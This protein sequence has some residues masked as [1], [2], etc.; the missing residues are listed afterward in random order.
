MNSFFYQTLYQVKQAYLSLQQ[1]PGF[2]FSVVTTLGITLGALLCVL[3]LAYVMLIKPLPYPDQDRLYR[4]E[5]QLISNENKV[6]GRAFTYPNLMHLYKNQ[7]T[8]SESVLSYFD[9]AVLTSSTDEPMV[10]ISF[11]T[12]QWFDIFATKMALGRPFES[13]EQVNTYNPVAIL[14]YQTWQAEFAGKDNILDEKIKFSGK[15][16]RVIGVT[17]QQNIE[18]PLAGPGYKTQIY[19][20]WD[21]NPTSDKQRLAWGND[22][23]GLSFIGKIK[24]ELAATFSATQMNQTLTNLVNDNWQNQVAS[25]EF[26]KG[27]GI[28]LEVSTLKSFIVADGEKSVYLLILGALGL[29]LIACTNIANLFVSRTAER[30]QQLAIRAA[31]GASKA[32]LFRTIMAE[33]GIIMLLSIVVAQIFTF[34]GFSILTYYLGDFLPRI[35][36][37]NLNSFSVIASIGLLVLLTFFFS[38]LCRKMINYRSLNSTLQSSG[39]GSGIQVSKK[40]RNILISSQI[41]I[42]TPLVFIN[43]VLYKDANALVEQ[44]LGYETENIMAV[45]L[46]LANIERDSRAQKLTELKLKLNNVPKIIDV[47]QGMRPSI[48]S[49]TALTDDATTKRYTA[50]GKDVDERYFE[51]I[52][53]VIIEGDNFSAADIKDDN[54]V[55]IINDVFAQLVSPNGSAIGMKFNNGLRVIGVVKSIHIPGREYVAAR[56]YMPASLA[57]NMLL[58]KLKPGQELSRTELIT[59][60]KEV[61]PSLSLF[62]FSSLTDYKNERLFAPMTTAITTVVLAILTLFLS[63][64]GLYGILSY[65]SQMRRF[66]IGTRLAI[67][68][69][70]KD[71]VTLVF[72]DNSG[73]M[74]SGIIISLLVLLGLY[75]GFR[76]SL[77]EYVSIELI[78][79]YM[80]T[81]ALIT[82]ISLFACYMPLR[83]YINKP[84]IHSLRGSD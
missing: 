47:S 81:L 42:A 38:H 45:V 33:I 79:L 72:R 15:S 12:P 25:E 74:V 83:Q 53:Q 75:L 78:P 63:G 41:A 54:R 17:A 43:I 36:E 40:V 77:I 58:I 71:I 22:Y 8:F 37:L 24:P 32:Q 6:D 20:P 2:V 59:S 3:T 62:S 55:A 65:S 29:V 69:K 48:F 18:L 52:N 27:W 4:V 7:T 70:G 11:V 28:R 66:E 23:S 82:L 68:A 73:A 21:F 51:M 26:F 64:L 10:T 46:S 30:Q 84:A 57:R 67:G 34:I 35:D 49:T 50:S 61:S 16:Y 56:F 14:S 1:K 19:V 44:P 31:V 60:L 76:D 5:H 80:M 13:S 39:K 9:A